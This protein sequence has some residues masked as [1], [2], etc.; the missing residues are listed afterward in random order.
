MIGSHNTMSYLKPTKWWM[1]LFNKWAKCQ[2]LTFEEQFN[3]GV[4]YFDI[5]L[6]LVDGCWH[7]CH[8][9]IDYGNVTEGFIKEKIPNIVGDNLVYFRFLLDVR[10]TPKNQELYRKQFKDIL[11]WIRSC[12]SSN[13]VINKAIVYWDWSTIPE[14]DG[15]V[16]EEEYHV[17]VKGKWYE[18]LFLGTKK[19]AD[20]VNKPLKDFY[21]LNVNKTILLDYINK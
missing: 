15:G 16:F 6:K 20:K 17:S 7:F 21:L 8:N 4:R 1:R 13:L 10:K 2:E 11:E 9:L 5:R 3:Y 18:Y 12:W 19:F 14:Y